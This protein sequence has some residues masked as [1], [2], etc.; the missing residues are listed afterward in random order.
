MVSVRRIFQERVDEINQYY[1][2][3]ENFLPVNSD[4]NINKI[5]KSNMLLMLHN[6]IES[7]ASNA[8]EE[9]HNNIHANS[10]SFNTLKAELKELIIKH[11]NNRNPKDFTASI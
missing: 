2:F 10:V 6:L 7:S 4:E 5:L 3:I 9:I 11:L 1:L 8:I